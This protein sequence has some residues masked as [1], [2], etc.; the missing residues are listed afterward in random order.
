MTHIQFIR[1]IALAI[2]AYVE[3]GDNPQANRQITNLGARIIKQRLC[4]RIMASSAYEKKSVEQ[5]SLSLLG[6]LFMQNA[7]GMSYLRGPIQDYL[8]LDDIDL[9]L[10]FQSVVI[11]TASH[12]L[13]HLWKDADQTSL[14]IW[15]NLHHSLKSH[16]DLILFPSDNPRWVALAEEMEI[17]PEMAPI[18]FNLLCQHIGEAIFEARGIGAI[19]IQVL[20]KITENPS[21]MRAILIEELFEAFREVYNVSRAS[22]Q[23]RLLLAEPENSL[24]AITLEK[25][26][27]NAL[28]KVGTIISK[29]DSLRKMSPEII[30]HFKMAID[31]IIADHSNGGICQSYYEYL[32]ESWVELGKDEYRKDFRAK[33][34]YLADTALQEFNSIMKDDYYE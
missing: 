31:L 33:F 28:E 2:R 29:H 6:G 11:R 10:R 24:F 30:N 13:Y 34:E 19:V 18:E 8:G 7:R 14:R 17:K 5:A 21:L 25:A 32:K 26:S 1:N 3:N 4:N 22:L 20:I 16:P 23:K 9:F 27:E 15:R 12:E